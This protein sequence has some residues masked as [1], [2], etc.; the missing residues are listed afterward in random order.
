MVLVNL[1]ETETETNANNVNIIVTENTAR[2]N[3]D[4]R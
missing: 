3:N 2:A 1:T 4:K